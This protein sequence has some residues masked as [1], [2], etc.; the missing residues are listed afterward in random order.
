M[1]LGVVI[2]LPCYADEH[3]NPRFSAGARFALCLGSIS[4]P[5][6][7]QSQTLPVWGKRI[8]IA[9]NEIVEGALR[10]NGEFVFFIDTDVLFPPTAFQTLLLRHRNNPELKVIS[11]VYWS[12]SNPTFPL[13]F[14]EMGRGSYLNW[15]VG[16]FLEDIF[17][18][19]MGLTLIHTDVFRKM[20]PPWFTI[21]YGLNI[22]PETG[23]MGASSMTEDLPFCERCHELGFK[24]S[25]DTGIQAGHYDEAS[26]NIFG[27]NPSMPQ[28]QGRSPNEHKTLYIGDILA[29]GEPADVLSTDKTLI[30][31][32]L[33]PPDV[34]PT[35]K[36]Y[37]E[38]K[39][40]D[41]AVK[42]EKLGDVLK[43]YVNHL[44][45][46]GQLFIMHP[47]F[48]EM[49]EVNPL[50]H[51]A[52][53]KPD[54]IEAHLQGLGLTEV[55]RT[56]DGAYFVIKGRKPKA[57][58]PLV[59]IIVVAHDAHEMT[60]NCIESLR[61]TEGEYEIVL[62]DNGSEEPYPNM[63]DRHIRLE[64]NLPYGQAVTEGVKISDQRAPYVLLLNNDTQII[65]TD[66]LV[67]LLQRIRGQG[68]VAAV[69][70]KQITPQGTIYHAGIAFD[71]RVPFHPFHGFAHDF[72][73]AQ[74][75]KMA[76]ALNFGCVLLRREM[77]EKFP[78][79]TRFGLAGNYEDIDW[80]LRV[81][82]AG[83]VLIYTP[84]ATIIHIGAGTFRSEIDKHGDEGKEW[85]DRSLEENRAR[86]LEK[87]KD[88]DGILFGE[89]PKA[90]EE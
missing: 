87:W 32:W 31:T 4:P 39:V 9:R 11:G 63:G 73:A 28:A 62:V 27:L 57:G 67:N 55:Q 17:A 34:I 80:C 15:K 81:R 41:P 36:K 19:G 7:F 48:A 14:H 75:E 40:K 18:T 77:L 29:G 22:D 42:F 72:N 8:D 66:W 25:V 16:D 79:D 69:G 2:G 24:V 78:L 52:I 59:S 90:K 56:K 64:R 10:Q 46:G 20:E 38:I 53:Y 61:S 37:K 68:N 3:G 89:E 76:L 1:S 58:H 70:P 86:F 12:K 88:E 84:S 45:D 6:N 51:D 47:D 35:D 82:K 21:N 26:G 5:M 13:I 43:E 85:H 74:E 50:S 30:P 33:G 65:Q 44:E 54:F 83:G 71:N 49:L 23:A 60:R